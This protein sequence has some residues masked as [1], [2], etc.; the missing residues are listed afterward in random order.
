MTFCYFSP[1]ENE[2]FGLLTKRLVCWSS[3]SMSVLLPPNI[4]ELST[5][6]LVLNRPEPF[7]PERWVTWVR[8]R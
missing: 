3:Q 7:D 4:K 2:R 1:R 6:V 5:L 8:G